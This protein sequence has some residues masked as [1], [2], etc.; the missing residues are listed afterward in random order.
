LKAQP[1]SFTRNLRRN[2]PIAAAIGLYF[3][4]GLLFIAQKPGLQYDEALLVAGAVHMEHSAASFDLQPATHAWTC[5]FPRCIPLMS[6]FYVG[7]IKEY[8]SL[9]FF[10]L[11]GPRTPVIRF[12]SLLLSALGIWG[13][14][15]LVAAGF[16]RRAA[17]LAA[18]AIAINPAFVTMSVF[19]NNAIAALMA[20]LG[21][22]CAGVAFYSARHSVAA[23]FAMGAAMGFAVWDRANIVWILASG[24]VAAIIVFR[25]RALIP[26]S[27]ALAVL[28]GGIIGGF[29]FLAYQVVSGAATW[30]A[31]KAF[32]VADP[33]A[34]LL[35]QRLFLFADVL[36]S[37]GEHRRM[38]A[39]PQLP[40]W[41]LWFFPAVVV[42]A[43]LVCVLWRPRQLF[44]QF[45]A[46]AFVLSSASL[47][48]S[49][50]Q[51]AE[52]HLF[53][54][55]PLAIVLVVL[56][57]FLLQT[58]YRRAW[59]V[60]A[61]LALIYASSALYWQV[62]GI[63]GLRATGGIGVWSDSG[64]ELARYLDQRLQNR[65]IKI[66]DWGLE[67]NEYVLTD[68][69]LQPL[70]IY[71]GP[72]EDVSAQGRPW[73]DE[74]REGGVFLLTGPDDRGFPKPSE[75]FLKA[76][77]AARP[78]MQRHS[79]AQRD[80]DTYAE[81]IEIAPNSIRGSARP[82]EVPQGRIPMGDI[83]FESQLTG[84]YP[85]EDGFRWTKRE[86]SAQLSVPEADPNGAQ[87]LMRVYI[88]EAAIQKL[89]AQTLSARFAGH[90]LAPQTW[91][92]PGQHVFRRQLD[93]AWLNP[94]QVQ[95][96]F[97]L[98]KAI[99]ATVSEPRELGIVVREISIEP[100]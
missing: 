30:K 14:Y 22:T 9:P 63:R 48:F 45:V 96:D 82:G 17:V 41:Q 3:F 46:L 66:L 67:F 47:F 58:K 90:V 57:C 50:L 27:H 89:G 20:G 94:G 64:I 78:V 13:I 77:A 15:R 12:V 87:L 35:R 70:E 81:V 85:P 7:A 56:A 29:P 42:L 68:G 18:F 74:I 38:W 8:V 59:M 60:S 6:A 16:D 79:I 40:L 51:V 33:M 25:R 76:L 5:V 55:V 24:V 23:A 75:G 4:W 11:F 43:C 54:L 53:V 72:S 10:A 98:D 69:R 1:D 97:S 39:G 61:A 2:G 83:G 71:S 34:A 52:H 31:Q 36:L 93:P 95:V 86:F 32:A 44:A 73:I 28:A 80:G 62:A 99:S 65:L 88:P 92:E 37:D 19:D 26:A 21:L 100:L 84:F 49:R 91:S